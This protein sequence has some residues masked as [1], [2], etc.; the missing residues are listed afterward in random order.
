MLRLLSDEDFKRAMVRGVL[1]VRPDIDL[2]RVQDVGLRTQKDVMV[3]DWAAAEGRV[4]LTHDAQTMPA[5]AY[6]RVLKGLPMP[7][8]FIVEQEESIGRII[9]EIILLAECSLE[10]EWERQVNYLPLK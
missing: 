9:E 3:L 7:G 10:G 5:H 4:L 8:V 1:R 6:Q 2:V